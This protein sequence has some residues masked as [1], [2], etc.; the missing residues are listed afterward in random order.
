MKESEKKHIEPTENAPYKFNGV[1]WK[2]KVSKNVYAHQQQQQ[3]KHMCLVYRFDFTSDCY[4]MWWCDYKIILLR[5]FCT[6]SDGNREQP[7]NK[8][9]NEKAKS[10]VFMKKL[11][12]FEIWTIVFKNLSEHT[13]LAIFGYSF[14]SDDDKISSFKF[15]YLVFLAEHF[16][17]IFSRDKMQTD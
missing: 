8:I 16:L 10:F 17:W 6:I 7:K 13:G 15:P 2:I 3:Q 12:S 4:F 5:K 11:L 1:W 9:E 14:G